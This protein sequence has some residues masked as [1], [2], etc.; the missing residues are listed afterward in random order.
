MVGN[1]YGP[2]KLPLSFQRAMNMVLGD[3]V[4]EKCL[5]YIDDIIVFGKDEREH[6]ENLKLVFERLTSQGVVVKP[7]KCKIGFLKLAFLGY[8]VSEKGVEMDPERSRVISELKAPGS[9]K[10]IQRFLGLINYYRRFIR[11]FAKRSFNMRSLVKSEGPWG[12]GS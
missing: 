9:V 2:E 3:I 4:G 6:R 7:K 8:L 5:V 11:N 10:E 1:A 12:G